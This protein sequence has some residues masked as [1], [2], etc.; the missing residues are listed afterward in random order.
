MIK[1]GLCIC[2]D[3][4]ERIHFGPVQPIIDKTASNRTPVLLS[5]DNSV[6]HGAINDFDHDEGTLSGMV[7]GHDTILMLLQKRQNDSEEQQKEVKQKPANSSQ[8]WK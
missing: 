2:Y 8:N 7:A 6:I 4:L 1:L 5:I 3:Q